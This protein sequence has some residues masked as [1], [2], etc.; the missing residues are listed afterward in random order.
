M[1]MLEARFLVCHFGWNDAKLFDSLRKQ[2]EAKQINTCPLSGSG[3]GLITVH[4]VLH[5][6]NCRTIGE[7]T[8]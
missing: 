2:Q 5:W 8:P 1:T 4:L 6:Q 3:A 7:N